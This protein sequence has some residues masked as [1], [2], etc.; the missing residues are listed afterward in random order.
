MEYGI[1][2]LHTSVRIGIKC[3]GLKNDSVLSNA[4]F[5]ILRL[6]H[7]KATSLVNGPIMFKKQ[8][9]E[10]YS[11]ILRQNICTELSVESF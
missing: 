6:K 3:T 1:S 10:N 2:T 7:N 11:S 8:Q 4:F 5:F 9:S